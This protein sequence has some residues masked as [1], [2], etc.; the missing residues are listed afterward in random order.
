MAANP[1][2]AAYIRAKAIELGID[3]EIALRVA[4]HE[5][6]NVFDPSKPDLGGDDRSSFGPWQL[7]YAGRSKSMPNPGLGDEFTRQTGLK[8]DDPSTWKQ[9]TDFALAQAKA[10]GWGPWMGAAAEGIGDW[11]GIR[12]GRGGGK[13]PKAQAVGGAGAYQPPNQYSIGPAS[14]ATTSPSSVTPPYGQG[15][16]SGAQPPQPGPQLVQD[17][18]N[19]G[20]VAAADQKSMLGAFGEGIGNIKIGA[21]AKRPSRDIADAARMDAPAVAPLAPVDPNRRMMLAQLM[22][23]LNSGRLYG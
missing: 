13:Q 22:A 6:L 19:P 10:G 8:A 3:P 15:Q 2:I 12:G 5:G 7:H 20:R 16:P 18:N 14:A 11:Q 21:P 1:E 23:Q 17:P 4:G 9:Q